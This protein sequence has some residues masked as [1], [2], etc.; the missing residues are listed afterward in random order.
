VPR[1]GSHAVEFA[2]LLGGGILITANLLVLGGIAA[3][4]AIDGGKLRLESR[5]DGIDRGARR[6]GRRALWN[7][8]RWIHLRRGGS[9]KQ[10]STGE[11][12]ASKE[13]SGRGCR[14]EIGHVR[15]SQGVRS[16][17]AAGPSHSPFFRQGHVVSAAPGWR[18]GLRNQR[19]QRSQV[20]ATYSLQPPRG[21]FPAAFGTEPVISSGST[22]RYEE[23]S[24]KSRDRQ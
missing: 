21:Q 5:A 8:L 24:A 20:I 4:A 6:R 1:L 17:R 19:F 7:S 13:P 16:L 3:A 23:A 11:R 12:G 14:E 10:Q 9:A 18:G 22:R 15:P 2:L